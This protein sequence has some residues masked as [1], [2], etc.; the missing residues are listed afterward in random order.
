MAKEAACEHTKGWGRSPG[1]GG[2]WR[3]EA[4]HCAELWSGFWAE[5]EWTG[6]VSGAR[7]LESGHYLN[8]YILSPILFRTYTKRNCPGKTS[9]ISP[10]TFSGSPRTPQG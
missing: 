5:S 2:S 4:N 3:R 7:S 9:K 1:M 8:P 10:G 6:L